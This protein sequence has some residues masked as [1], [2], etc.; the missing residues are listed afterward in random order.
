MSNQ[1]EERLD[2]EMFLKGFR[3]PQAVARYT[4]GP[5]RFVPGVDALHRMTGLLLSE[6]AKPDAR[7]YDA[8]R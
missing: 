6:R 5:K 4:D 2:Q 3:D 1:A 8:G 7:G